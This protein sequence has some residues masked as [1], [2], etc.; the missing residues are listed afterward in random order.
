MPGDV[1]QR[2][3][4]GARFEQLDDGLLALAE[5]AGAQRRRILEAQLRHR[6]GV[7]AAADDRHGR[8]SAPRS[9]R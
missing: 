2:A 7:L 9:R 6:G 3:A 8:E 5:R 4:A 1:G